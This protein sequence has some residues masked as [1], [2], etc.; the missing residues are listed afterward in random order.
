MKMLE[1]NMTIKE[2]GGI[3]KERMA[4]S[5]AHFVTRESIR[6]YRN[7]ENGIQK[8]FTISL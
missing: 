7:T 2:S 3:T 1:Q 8:E 5:Q 4:A 6:D